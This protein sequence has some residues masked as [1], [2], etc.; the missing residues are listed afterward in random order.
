MLFLLLC[1]NLVFFLLVL[2]SD[3]DGQM[4]YLEQFGSTN[5]RFNFPLCF[6]TMRC[7]RD[8]VLNSLSPAS[9]FKESALRKQS[10]Y[11]KFD[12]L[13][14]ES[15]KKAGAPTVHINPPRPSSLASRYGPPPIPSCCSHYHD[16]VII[17][18][19]V[20]PVLVFSH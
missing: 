1:N 20:F 13:M 16:L 6:C 15:P 9:Q 17:F 3:L 8:S 7:C 12:P 4:D 19:R 18:L 2:L 5:V 11:L 10:L 14:R